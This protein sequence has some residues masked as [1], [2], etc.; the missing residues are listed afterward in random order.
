M[1]GFPFSCGDGSGCHH[2]SRMRDRT[3]S[4]YG[5]LSFIWRLYGRG[6]CD[7]YQLDGPGTAQEPSAQNIRTGMLSVH[8]LHISV[9][10]PQHGREL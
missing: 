6:R 10:Q 8:A 3:L 4:F 7:R 2:F 9:R 5:P 1:S